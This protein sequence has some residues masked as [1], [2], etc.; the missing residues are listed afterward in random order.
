MCAE[1]C[2]EVHDSVAVVM[3]PHLLGLK[4]SMCFS[5]IGSCNI[6]N[7]FCVLKKNVVGF[8]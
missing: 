6:R 1:G 4:M 8:T 3:I 5:R 7:Q 2:S